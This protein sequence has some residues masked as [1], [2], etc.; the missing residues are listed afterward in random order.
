MI[1]FSGKEFQ[2]L[3]LL[4][5]NRGQVFTKENIFDKIWVIMNMV[6]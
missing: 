1:Y 4:V 5:N 6:I 2:I 3:E